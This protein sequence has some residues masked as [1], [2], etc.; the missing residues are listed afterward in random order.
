MQQ[1]GG[2]KGC[3]DALVSPDSSRVFPWA[4]RAGLL[5]LSSACPALGWIPPDLSSAELVQR[6][7]AQGEV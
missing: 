3:P 5:G 6:D 1:C 2:G 7:T 4:C